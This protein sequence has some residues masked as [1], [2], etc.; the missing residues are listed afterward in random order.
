[1]AQENINSE[2]PAE[3]ERLTNRINP[4]DKLREMLD[5]GYITE[6]VFR[7]ALAE[8]KEASERKEIVER[9]MV[10]RT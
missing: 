7:S 10:D 3:S 6:D 2:V 9:M 8:S 1:M 5:K 4:E